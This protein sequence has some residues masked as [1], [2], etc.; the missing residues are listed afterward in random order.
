MKVKDLIKLLENV[1]P[2]HNI[3]LSKDSEGNDY[4]PLYSFEIGRYLPESTWSG[5]VE[6]GDDMDEDSDSPIDSIV[7]FPIN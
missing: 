2:D 4:S 5:Y 3:I 7:L 6:F 1:D